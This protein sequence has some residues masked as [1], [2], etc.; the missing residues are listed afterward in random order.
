[1]VFRILIN[2][3][4]RRQPKEKG[5]KAKEKNKFNFVELIVICQAAPNG[6]ADLPSDFMRSTRKELFTPVVVRI[7]K[8]PKQ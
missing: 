1:M 6:W 8:N 4:L 3:S 2:L 5:W 7:Y